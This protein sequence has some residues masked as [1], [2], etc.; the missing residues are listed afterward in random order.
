MALPRSTVPG[1]VDKDGGMRLAVAVP[2]LATTVSGTVTVSIPS[3][4]FRPGQQTE[5]FFDIGQDGGLLITN[6]SPVT[7]NK[8]NY[9]VSII[10]NNP[11]GSTV[12]ALT[13]N[14][15]LVQE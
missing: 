9:S 13:R 2:S 10:F 15:W 3:R 8:P 6:V 7:G 14:V 4:K 11:T 12:G 1:C 5:A